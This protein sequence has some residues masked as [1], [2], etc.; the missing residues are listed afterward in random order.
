MATIPQTP[1]RSRPRTGHNPDLHNHS[2]LSSGGR[3]SALDL[4]DI[5]AMTA[6]SDHGLLVGLADDDHLQYLLLAGRSGGQ[7]AIGGTASGNDL[8]LRSTSHATR[9]SVIFG[10]TATT[11][12]DETLDSIGIGT[13]SPSA[14]LHVRG[15]AAAASYVIDAVTAFEP[16]WDA[17][18]APTGSDVSDANDGTFWLN[19]TITASTQTVSCSVVGGTIT[20]ASSFTVATRMFRTSGHTGTFRF[21]VYDSAGA[22]LASLSYNIS[23]LPTGA[24][25]QTFLCDQAVASGTANRIV[26]SLTISVGGSGG[27]YRVPLLS[28]TGA[29]SA[30]DPLSLWDLGG[31]SL[32]EINEVGRFVTTIAPQFDIASAAA[33][34]IWT[35]TD[36]SGNG[37]WR[38]FASHLDDDLEAIAAIADG[39][40]GLLAKTAANTWAL[41][42]LAAPAAGFTITNPG[43]VAGNPTFVLAN[44]L[45]ALEGLATTSIIPQRTAS[46]TWTGLAASRGGV[47][48]GN[49][50]PA[51]AVTAVGAA[52][53]ILASDGTDTAFRALSALTSAEFL[54]S[55]FRVIGSATATKKL[56]FEVDGF[57]AATTRTLTPQDAS[58]TIAGLETAQTFTAAQV[59]KSVANT[60]SLIVDTTI[61]NTANPFEVRLDGSPTL[62]VD[63]TTA[64]THIGTA[65]IGGGTVVINGVGG[66]QFDIASATTD[67]LWTST[68]AA[69]VGLWKTPTFKDSLFKVVDESDATKTAVLSLGGATT[70]ADLTLAWSGTAD[71]TV[72]IPNATTTLAGLAVVE[73][74]TAA[75]TFGVAVDDTPILNIN[76]Y[77]NTVA[78][79]NDFLVITD[80]SSLSNTGFTMTLAH[81]GIAANV[82]Y[83]LPLS[84][85]TLVGTNETTTLL[86]K[87]LSGTGSYVRCGTGH[88][89]FS[90]ATSTTQYF[91]FVLT[92]L[93]AAR[94]FTLTDKN[95]N[96]D[97]GTYTPTLTN[98]TNLAAS[99]AYQCQYSRNGTV[100][101]VSGKVDIDPTIA[102]A[103]ALGI[104]L[105]IASNLGAAED[106][107]G[108]AFASGIA[109]QGAAIRG[110]AANDRAEMA[111]V[112]ADITNQP[113]YFTFAYEII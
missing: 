3:I 90:N 39:S 49:S 62:Y 7:T 15:T 92:A 71:R 52:N 36:A 81:Q 43:G 9:G 70:G 111:W 85:A 82:R 93:T 53:T 72:T 14:R 84:S 86:N 48:I 25:D 78:A 67:F 42:T 50:T 112:A 8:T 12:Y 57:T 107:A 83:T 101:T 102:G 37:E 94:T 61:G 65:N 18:A 108:A 73:T 38:S 30:G 75:Q 5:P 54:D 96:L 16:D 59:I 79:S 13:A 4:L 106:C 32:S 69:G 105:P 64:R 20:P 110:D 24:T 99:T 47:L 26:L 103:C 87:T 41:R 46:D 68:D 17:S 6:I 60:I 22:G 98:V 58:Y 77:G 51:W 19:E 76:S 31:S 104:T 55:A 40:T 29:G 88:T 11:A 91:N 34:Y 10:A 95:H 66:I 21:I 89:R 45:A 27:Q 74:F 100:V 56:A 28:F 63:G 2:D 1:R 80:T 33:D 109:G 35:A 113:M 23:T 44:D 97:Y